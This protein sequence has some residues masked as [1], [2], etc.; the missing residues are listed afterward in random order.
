MVDE[1]AAAAL[2][3]EVDGVPYWWHTIDLGHGVVTPGGSGDMSQL[4]NRLALPD[5]LRGKTVLDIGA[6]DG[7]YSFECERRGA[8]R[9]VASDLFAWRHTGTNGKAGFEVARRALGSHVEDMEIDVFEISPE[10][11]GMF[12]IVLFLG[13]LYHL[14]DPMRGLAHAASVTRE[15]LV[16]ETH[17]DLLDLERP[18]M[19]FYPGT[20]LGGDATNWFGPNMAALFGMLKSLG[21]EDADLVRLEPQVG[22][23]EWLRTT[24]TGD[25]TQG[26]RRA[27]VHARPEPSLENVDG[28][29][30]PQHA[31]AGTRREPK[32]RPDEPSSTASHGESPTDESG[33]TVAEDHGSEL[34]SCPEFRGGSE[35]R[36]RSLSK[37][38]QVHA[39][40]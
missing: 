40:S 26:S 27:V 39:Q 17:V 32:H 23:E 24:G 2:Q 12:D 20:E 34:M 11:V 9:V 15:L 10:T 18:A 1:G 31:T 13:V 16:V 8:A 36:I 6:W 4:L 38:L 3:K 28:K 22:D 29:E 30:P 21:L 35:T 37:E 25:G 5:D 33:A 14:Q 19:A 7:F